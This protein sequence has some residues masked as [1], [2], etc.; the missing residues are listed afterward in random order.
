MASRSRPALTWATSVQIEG[1]VADGVAALRRGDGPQ[2]QVH[3]SGNLLQ[4]LLRHGLVD[5]LRLSVF[6]VVLG[7]GKRLFA[8]GAV[9]VGLTLVESAVSGTGVFMGTYRPAGP[10]PIG[11]FPLD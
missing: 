4:T 11:S 1:D 2:P 6:P 9:P 5:E 10:V 8:D 3:R 7:T